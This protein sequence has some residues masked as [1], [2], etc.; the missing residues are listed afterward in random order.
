MHEDSLPDILNSRIVNN[1]PETEIAAM[2][3]LARRCLN[4]NGKKR[5]TMKQVAMELELIKAS[6]AGDAIE[7]VDEESETDEI[8][9]SWNAKSFS[10]DVYINYN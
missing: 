6:K 5:P 3:K 2:S 4:L 10:V 7:E 8:I 9:E 1:S